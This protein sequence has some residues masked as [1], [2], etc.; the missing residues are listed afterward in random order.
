MTQKLV[1][2]GAGMASGRMLEH[3]FDAGFDA[4]TSRCSTPN[5]AA[6]TTG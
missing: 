3:L 6:I 2:I 1:V 4:G 5:R